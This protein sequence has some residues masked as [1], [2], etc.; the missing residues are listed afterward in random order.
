MRRFLRSTFIA[1]LLVMLAFAPVV[2]A[3]ALFL[4]KETHRHFVKRTLA[5]WLPASLYETISIARPQLAE[6]RFEH[7]H[8]FELRGEMFDIITRT[9]TPDSIHFVVWR[10]SWE[11]RQNERISSLLSLQF[12]QPPD[13]ATSTPQHTLLH[14]YSVLKHL[15][16]TAFSDV[17]SPAFSSFHPETAKQICT[18]R[19]APDPREQPPRFM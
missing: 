4:S 11:T 3:A 7:D 9:E 13:D 5:S 17:P 6:L 15:L 14:F 18:G 2:L 19:D 12:Q 1:R 10:D 8:E 16:P